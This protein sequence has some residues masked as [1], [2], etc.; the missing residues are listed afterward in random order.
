MPLTAHSAIVF[1]GGY[2]RSGTTMMQGILS[3]APEMGEVTDECK[4]FMWLTEAYVLGERRFQRETADYFADKEALTRF[5]SKAVVERYLQLIE[6][7]FGDARTVMKEPGFLYQFPDVAELMPNAQFIVMH[8]DIRDIVASQ[9]VR[10]QRDGRRFG[11]R[12]A[13]IEVQEFAEMFRWLHSFWSMPFA[14]R[15]RLVS[16]EDLVC[17]P[18]RELPPIASFLGISA[19]RTDRWPTKRAQPDT[20]HTELDTKP[21][22]AASVG[23]HWSVLPAQLRQNVVHWAQRAEQEKG[24]TCFHSAVDAARP[25]YDTADRR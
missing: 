18:E 15:M 8:R 12:E 14:S 10:A 25:I 11:D 23:K 16:Y 7:R 13:Y 19:L 2:P 5:H 3:T 22:S 4:Y 24:V 6:E 17:D 20:R 1:L 21:I 9:L